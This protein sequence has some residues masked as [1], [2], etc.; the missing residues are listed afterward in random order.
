M[1]PSPTE[2]ADKFPKCVAFDA[3][4]TLIEPVPP[5]SQVYFD[6]ARR[7]GSRLAADDIAR[8][9]RTAFRDS[10]RNGSG[11]SSA[12]PLATSEKLEYERWR[13]IV[14]VV[15][16]DVA[17][18]QC[19][20][21]ELFAHFARPDAWRL[22][23]D[24][25]AALGQLSKCGVRLAIASN[26]DRR[27]HAICDALPVLQAISCRAISSEIGF[28]KP[29]PR[30]FE[31]LLQAAGCRADELLVVGDDHENDVAGPRRLGIAAVQVDRRGHADAPAVRS[32]AE[33]PA[34][35]GCYLAEQL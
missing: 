23:D 35:I 1:T 34:A 18:S 14:G 8:R 33:L 9:F 12:D 5:A 31:A 25:P 21:E 10:E 6:V 4:G 17:D 3:V 13:A 28:R 29:S 20:F 32:L 11:G 22:F 30:F 2:P 19:C 7:H 24:V 26:F 27:L 15:I 16:D